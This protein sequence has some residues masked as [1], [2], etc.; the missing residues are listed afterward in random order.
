MYSYIVNELFVFIE[1][2]F[3][4]IKECVISGYF[5]GGYG[6]LVIGMCNFNKFVLVLVFSFILNFLDCL[7]GEK[8]LGWYLGDD[9]VVW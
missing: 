4:V 7:W 3:F 2:E 8:V 9:K 5:M 1:S 6:V